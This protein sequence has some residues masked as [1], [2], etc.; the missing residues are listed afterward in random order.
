MGDH[1]Y[2]DGKNFYKPDKYKANLNRQR[3]MR[4]SDFEDKVTTKRNDDY[5]ISSRRINK[6]QDDTEYSFN[7]I[8]N[9]QEDN[10]DISGEENFSKNQS[11]SKKRT[12]P[13]LENNK[14]HY[15]S[16]SA[17]GRYSSKRKS[18]ANKGRVAVFLVAGVLIC[19]VIVFTVVQIIKSNH[20]IIPVAKETESVLEPAKTQAVTQQETAKTQNNTAEALTF[21]KPNP[22]DDN[23]DGYFDNGYFVWNDTIFELFYG[24]DDTALSYAQAINKY[25]GELGDSIKT[26]VMVIPT[27]VEMGLPSRFTE[28]GQVTSNSQKDNISTVYKNL[29]NNVTAINCYNQLSEHCNEYIYFNTDHHWTGLGAY[30]AYSAFAKASNQEVLSLDSCKKQTIEGFSGTLLSNISG[31]APTDTVEYWEFPY[32]TSNDIYYESAGTPE[33]LTVYYGGAESGTLTY[34]V[35]IWGDQPLEVLHSDRNTGKKIAIVKESFGNALVPYFTYNYDE[36]HVIDF[37]YWEGNLKKYCEEQGITEV[38][39]ANGVMS[40]NT[41]S[42]IDAM[43]TL[44][45]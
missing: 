26:Y 28:S 32:E 45:K 10:F 6:K 25:A 27:N 12:N 38:L 37:R 19:A 5:F 1:R 13:A 34:G 3:A 7:R 18:G 30:Y 15:T 39:F 21:N 4:A 9:Y 44:F 31:N 35:F 29:D 24:S 14:N 2:S 23:S 22:K 42:Q 43:S 16:N 8:N 20:N 33:N 11:F 36:V 40:A 41:S 17:G